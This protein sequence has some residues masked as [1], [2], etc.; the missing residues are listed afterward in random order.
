[1]NHSNDLMVKIL[2]I[3]FSVETE[4]FFNWNRNIE[5]LV[6]WSFE[7][8]ELADCFF[9]INY[10]IVRRHGNLKLYALLIVTLQFSAWI[11]N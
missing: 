11:I 4:T 3:F 1:M 5:V 8:P 10:V 7:D 2:R 6:T 9:I